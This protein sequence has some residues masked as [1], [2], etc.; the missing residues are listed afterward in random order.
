V[1]A[2]IALLSIIGC[3]TQE[4]IEARRRATAACYER[5]WTVYSGE[6]MPPQDARRREER[7]RAEEERRRAEDQ[8]KADREAALQQACISAGSRWLSLMP[9]SGQC[10]DLPARR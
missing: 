8:R 9:G 1:I 6:C 3:A 4:Q 5:G 2:L 7:D 10:Y